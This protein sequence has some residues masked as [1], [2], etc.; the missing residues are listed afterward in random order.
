MLQ[1]LDAAVPNA[2]DAAHLHAAAAPVH[3]CHRAAKEAGCQFV[4]QTL[5]QQAQD[6]RRAGGSRVALA[7]ADADAAAACDGRLCSCLYC[8]DCGCTL[9]SRSIFHDIPQVQDAEDDAR[10]RQGR[11]YC[12]LCSHKHSSG[13]TAKALSTV[14]FSVAASVPDVNGQNQVP[15]YRTAAA[16]LQTSM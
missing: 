1:V 9:A 11:P 3:S 4:Q 15:A 6:H 14:L 10:V 7:A 5:P 16:A 2:V 13:F 8:C 12:G